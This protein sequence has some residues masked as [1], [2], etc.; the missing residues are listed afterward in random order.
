MSSTVLF[1]KNKIKH[2]GFVKRTADVIW[3]GRTA[4]E[5][6][7]TNKLFYLN[8]GQQ[9]IMS[10]FNA[11]FQWRMDFFLAIH[12]NLRFKNKIQYVLRPLQRTTRRGLQSNCLCMQLYK[13]FLNRIKLK[14][15][16][17][18]ERNLKPL[19]GNL[20]CKFIKQLLWGCYSISKTF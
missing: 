8:F 13:T 15:L 12:T 20:I 10:V 19:G 4:T 3:E 14:L 5:L 16:N 1:L 7:A 18:A 6:K 2:L 17:T 9:T 11:T